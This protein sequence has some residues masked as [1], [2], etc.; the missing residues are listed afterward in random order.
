MFA[1][2][3]SLRSFPEALSITPFLLGGTGVN[4]IEK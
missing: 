4:R 2:G 3:Q 1:P